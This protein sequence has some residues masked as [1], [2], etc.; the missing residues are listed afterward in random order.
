LTV[1]PRRRRQLS[2]WIGIILVTL[3]F[4]IYPTYLI[5]AILPISLLS[6]SGVAVGLLAVSWGMFCAG[7]VLVGKQGLAILKRRIFS[8]WGRG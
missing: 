6:R 3:S 1:S 8:R 2:F 5:V 4:G 7:S